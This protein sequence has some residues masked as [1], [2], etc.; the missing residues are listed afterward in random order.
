MQKEHHS[1][2]A[3]NSHIPKVE[4]AV[5]RL[6]GPK[7]AEGKGTM[8]N[9]HRDPQGRFT[10]GNPGG[11]GRPRRA[12]EREYLAAMSDAVSLD[13]WREI[14]KA[15][16][17]ELTGVF[18]PLVLVRCAMFFLWPKRGVNDP[19]LWSRRA[20]RPLRLRRGRSR[21]LT[22]ER[23]DDRCLLGFLAPAPYPAGEV[24]NSVAVADFNGD[25]NLDLAVAN[26]GEYPFD[27]GTDVTVLLAD[28]K[29]GFEAPIRYGRGRN[30]FSVVAGDF[31][32]DGKPD[33]AVAYS[34]SND[35]GPGY[36]TVLL[37]NGDGTFQWSANYAT[38]DAPRS[39]AVGDFNGDGNLDL[40]VTNFLA[41]TV[42]I[43]LG[44]G[45][46]TF[47]SPVSYEAGPFPSSVAVG[48]FHGSGKLDLAVTNEDVGTVSILPGNGD[49]SF[50][51]PASYPVGSMPR[52]VT[53]ADL[54][55]DNKP[56]LAVANFGSDTVSVLLNNGDG[57]F[58]DAVSYATGPG[59]ASVA[60][61]DFNVD[62]IPDLVTANLYSTTVSVLLGNGDGTF[63]P[64]QN[65]GAGAYPS[66]VAVAD[67]NGDGF[68]DL[69][70]T[71]ALDPA[72]TISVLLNNDDWTSS[73]GGA[74]ARIPKSSP[75]GSDFNSTA[76]WGLAGADQV[77]TAWPN[78]SLVG[79]SVAGVPGAG[80][81]PPRLAEW[82]GTHS[83]A[84]SA[85]EEQRVVGSRFQHGA[86]PAV[87]DCLVDDIRRA[88][89]PPD[90]AFPVLYEE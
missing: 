30:P 71:N 86:R 12:V 57:T 77:R 2:F 66:S 25:G 82:D 5:G 90:W 19:L 45:D 26:V 21:P 59:P 4:M 32:G 29:G 80:K 67:F 87:P 20:H 84:A 16:V 52:S 6:I 75:A 24:P 68:P 7:T 55:G 10:V 17:G 34:L 36:V 35:G 47:N 89:L 33:L 39:L 60:V 69:V 13:E 63:L 64:A 48:D 56:D 79:F 42:S 38:G 70:V 14:V 62:G 76:L 41:T 51:P 58:Q 72:G 11:P 46:G 81:V 37:N 54:N 88:S 27:P 53:V 85:A 18:P 15:A 78:R 50:G 22:L 3:L 49:G 9:G 73:P 44:K 61:G 65:Y 23:L 28:G 83:C 43:L 74:A 1:H 31:N 8:D 40:V